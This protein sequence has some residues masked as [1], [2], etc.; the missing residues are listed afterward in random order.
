LNSR[1]YTEIDL[2]RHVYLEDSY[3]LDVVARAGLVTFCLDVAL[4]PEHELYEK[5]SAEQHSYRRAKM[6]FDGVRE[7]VWNYAGYRPARDAT[8][9]IDWGNIDSFLVQDGRY[10]L[11]GDWGRMEL[12]CENVDFNFDED[13]S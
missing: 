4:T 10:S 11:E 12:V 6:I 13:Q 1:P 9:E 8:G 3:V 2:L 5:P 7:L